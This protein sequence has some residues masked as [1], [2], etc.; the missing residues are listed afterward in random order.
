MRS[1]AAGEHIQLIDAA[2]E[3]PPSRD[4]FADFCHFTTRGA[5]L[6]AAHLA[7]EFT[8]QNEL[9]PAQNSE[10]L[11]THKEPVSPAH[12]AP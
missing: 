2:H 3:I 4:Y 8:S 11:E 6:M 10:T 5:G 7:D 9:E 1:L 12:D